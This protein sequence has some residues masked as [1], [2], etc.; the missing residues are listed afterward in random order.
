MTFSLDGADIVVCGAGPAGMTA[1]LVLADAGA[2]VTLLERAPEPMIAGAGTLLEPIGLAVLDAL[3]L[4]D[5]LRRAG[6]RIASP[7]I[8]SARGT[9]L[10]P[11][12]VPSVGAGLDNVLAIRHSRLT[13]IMLDA[14][15]KRSAIVTRFGADVSAA[16]PTGA[17]DLRWHDLRSTIAADLVIGADGTSSVVRAG[18][19]FVVRTR[20]AG[21]YLSVLLDGGGLNLAGEYWTSLGFFGGAQVDATTIHVYADASAPS[22]AT[23]VADRNLPAL[24]DVWAAALPLAGHIMHYIDRFDR[25]L[26]NHPVR[27]DCARWS[28][29]RLVLVG[30]AAHAMAPTFA[31]GATSAIVDAAVLGIELAVGV[32]LSESLARY[33]KR[34][35]P[36]VRRVQ[37]GADRL[38]ALA[39]VRNPALRLARDAALRPAGRLPAACTRLAGT[40]QPEN[41]AG[42]HRAVTRLQGPS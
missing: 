25:I 24:A 18:G 10:L 39:R 33:A 12:G 16:D 17:V 28:A 40:A 19:D 8:R 14:I 38:C 37:D 21:P 7:A 41:T 4:G 23:A 34:R 30:D 2:A 26:I 13:E 20:S 11:A 27:V 31:Q 35:Q 3:G 1:A 15:G 5:A 29:G 9:A 36:A 6:R 42:L 22:V 32:S